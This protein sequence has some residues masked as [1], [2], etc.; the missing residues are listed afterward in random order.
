M[1]NFKNF[2]LV[3]G[4]VP[5]ILMSGCAKEKLKPSA[6]AQEAINRSKMQDSVQHQVNYLIEEG[7]DFVYSKNYN[8]AMMVAK[9]ILA[10]LDANSQEAKDIFDQ[11]KAEMQKAAQ[12]AKTEMKNKLG[13]LGK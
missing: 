5:F 12:T 9:Y 7:Q 10:S 1:K 4:L 11:A 13:T 2:F 8:Q 3:V 6:N